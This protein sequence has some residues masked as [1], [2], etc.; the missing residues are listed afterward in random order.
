MEGVI[1]DPTEDPVKNTACLTNV[2]HRRW[3]KGGVRCLGSVG[4]RSSPEQSTHSHSLSFPAE[5]P[6]TQ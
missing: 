4:A 1:G 2:A 3:A 5:V 6:D